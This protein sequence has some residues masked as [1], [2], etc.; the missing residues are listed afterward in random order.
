MGFTLQNRSPSF[1]KYNI[2]I[3]YDVNNIELMI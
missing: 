1:K 2:E 3:E